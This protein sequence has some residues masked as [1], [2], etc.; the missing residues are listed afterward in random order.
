MN[1]K[2]FD[3]IF[4]DK[5]NE[6]SAFSGADDNWQKLNFRLDLVA[7]VPA[8][9]LPA[10]PAPMI[11]LHQGWLYAAMS[12]LAV[13]NVWLWL[14]MRDVNRQNEALQKVVAVVQTN[15]KDTVYRID[16][17][18]QKVYLID[19]HS[20]SEN[21]TAVT[22]A[23]YAAL[24]AKRVLQNQV[25]NVASSKSIESKNLK[26]QVS[27]EDKK[28]QIIEKAP[29]N[30]SDKVANALNNT[31]ATDS[32]TLNVTKSGKKVVLNNVSNE[33]KVSKQV[34]NDVANGSDITKNGNTTAV[35]TVSKD[36]KSVDNPTPNAFVA[37]GTTNSTTPSMTDLANPKTVDANEVQNKILNKADLLLLPLES[38][39]LVAIEVPEKESESIH[40]AGTMQPIK[41]KKQH[42]IFPKMSMPEVNIGI[43][44]AGMP[45][46]HKTNGFGIGTDIGLSRNWSVIASVEKHEAHFDMGHRDEKF[47]LPPPPI[48]PVGHRLMHL[49]GEYRDF[50]LNLGAKYVFLTSKKYRPFVTAQHVWKKAPASVVAFDYEKP[51][52]EINRYVQVV[53]DKS[54]ANIWQFGAGVTGDF[55]NR[56]S[57]NAGLNYMFDFNKVN[58]NTNPLTLR[59]SIYYRL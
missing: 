37:N 35:T 56:F 20:N 18:Y 6:E 11:G 15:R 8:P 51:T 52:G 58:R 54:F 5:L 22:P 36:T 24:S 53:E 17:I 46:K 21:L 32:K 44:V 4:S 19:N 29:L 40:V 47:H 45:G 10:P 59:A 49:E 9:V 16:T 30:R 31:I 41:V 1:D 57:W 42:N 2:D 43:V 34:E 39:P 50:R 38:K 48:V 13:G 7:P 14:Q 55:T 27:I 33:N 12:A 28:Q 23:E 25:S 3:Q 26:N